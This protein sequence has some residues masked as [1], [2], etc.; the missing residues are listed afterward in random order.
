MSITIMSQ[1]RYDKECSEGTQIC[2]MCGQHN[3]EEKHY[4]WYCGARE[5]VP[6]SEAG[7]IR[8]SDKLPVSR[9]DNSYTVDSMIVSDFKEFNERVEEFKLATKDNL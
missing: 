9:A 8:S 1:E 2:I 6:M 4:C 7:C 5:I 3:S